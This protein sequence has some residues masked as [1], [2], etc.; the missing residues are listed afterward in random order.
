MK[1]FKLK[2]PITTVNGVKLDAPINEISIKRRP[3]ARDL[4][5]AAEHSE[6]VARQTGFLIA[7]LSDRTPDEIAELDF[8]DFSELGREV[9]GFL[10]STQGSTSAKS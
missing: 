8:A 2:H 6:N 1:T 4:Y 9:A 3:K 7:L 10:E 5:R